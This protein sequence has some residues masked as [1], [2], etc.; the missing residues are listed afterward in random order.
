ML[1]LRDFESLFLLVSLAGSLL[2]ASP[3]LSSVFASR[4]GEKFSE[5]YVLGTN[6]MDPV[7]PFDVKG[8]DTYSIILG[9]GN[10]MGSSSY[11][12]LY[13]KLRNQRE[14]LPNS[15]ANMPSNLPALYE[16]RVLLH[17][18]EVWQAPLDFSFGGPHYSSNSCAL[19][20]LTI[21]SLTFHVDKEGFWD[22]EGKGF[23][24]QLFFELW[25]YS[26]ES[27]VFRFHDRYVGI[28]LNM[29]A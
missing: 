4:T 12:A 26:P 2:I 27:K 3:I 19:T 6:G 1:K 16:Y 10:H 5:L 13:V 21:D 17:D 9:I 11:Y 23:F 24:F 20:S 14:S 15:T 25:I 22:S 28:W 29:T 18:G 8:N 7:Y